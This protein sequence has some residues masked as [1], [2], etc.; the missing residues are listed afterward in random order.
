M[1]ST[2]LLIPKINPESLFS[3]S[4]SYNCDPLKTAVTYILD[5]LR[6]NSES[7]A[8]LKEK[9]DSSVAHV[10]QQ[11]ASPGSFSDLQA[12]VTSLEE[13]VSFLETKER[14]P[15]FGRTSLRQAS[16]VKENNAPMLQSEQKA[17]YVALDPSKPISISP[18]T[19]EIKA[20]LE[21]VP[22]SESKQLYSDNVALPPLIAMIQQEND[23]RI[24]ALE[25][26]MKKQRQRP[27]R[28]PSL[29]DA[30]KLLEAPSKEYDSNFAAFVEIFEFY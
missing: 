27:S 3:I 8:V 6:L 10:I 2:E 13:R 5:Q 7:I 4:F 30:K 26:D 21:T 29:S 24:T 22:A 17:E 14:N 16:G 28:P 23:K 19:A 15:A 11:T 25:N 9:T 18:I 20:A 1:A 12:K